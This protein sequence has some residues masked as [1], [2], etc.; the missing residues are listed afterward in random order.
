MRDGLS[1][2]MLLFNWRATVEEA[3]GAG[4]KLT[5]VDGLRVVTR[6]SAAV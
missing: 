3:R 1:I 4:K 6:T 2:L 5:A